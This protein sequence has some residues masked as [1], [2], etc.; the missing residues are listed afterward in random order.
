MTIYMGPK[1]S[2]SAWT[3]DIFIAENPT[4]FFSGVQ[5]FDRYSRSAYRQHS[6]DDVESRKVSDAK[7]NQKKPERENSFRES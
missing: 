1:F 6:Q 7:F 5:M 3:S 2:Y 4:T